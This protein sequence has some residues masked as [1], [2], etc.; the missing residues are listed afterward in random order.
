MEQDTV[1][2]KEREIA[3]GKAEARSEVRLTAAPRQKTGSR[4]F[5]ILGALLLIAAAGIYLWIHSLGRE[6]TDDAQVDGHI[7]PVSSKI[8][9]KVSE[10]LVDDNQQVKKGE[11]MARIDPRDYQVKADQAQAALAVALSQAKGADVGVPLVRETTTSDTSIAEA[12]LGSAQADYDE[13]KTE[14]E[15][16][17]GAD[18]SFARANVDAAQATAER[19]QEDLKRMKGLVD[20]EEISKLEY[21]SYLAQARVADSQL[22]AA[23]EKL[24]GANQDAATKKA[25]MLAAEARVAQA[26]AAIS[27]ARANEQQVNVRT[28]DA[29]SAA[30]NVQQAKANL[31]AAELNLGYTVIVAPEDGVVTKKSVEVGQIVQ[32]GQGLLMLIPLN[33][34]WITANFKETQLADVRPGQRAEVKADLSGETYAGHV[35]S[36][37]AATGTRMSLLPPENATGNY[38]KVVQRIPIKIVLDPIPGG[39]HVLRPGM[40]VEAT[41]F[42]K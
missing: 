26:R 13:A 32:Q 2:D 10:V 1:L 9:G 22:A 30:A 29:A 31:E 12:Q 41:V 11:V 40:N 6:S 23:K 27:Q 24:I 39:N 21:D 36:I 19:T 28:A 3:P 37:A 42:T 20:K 38:V 33:D 5:I 35:D 14:Y 25:A 18:I 4:K 34:V 17:S 7:I 8:Y 15:R 16:A